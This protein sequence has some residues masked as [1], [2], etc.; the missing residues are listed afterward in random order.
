MKRILLIFMVCAL[1]ATPA[2]SNLTFTTS[3][4]LNFDVISDYTND[5]GDAWY[6]G[7]YTTTAGYGP[8]LPPGHVGLVAHAVGKYA[9]GDE[10]QIE[11]LGLGLTN[12]DLSTDDTLV[13][14]ISND[15]DDLWKYKLFVDDG[16]FAGTRYESGSWTSVSGY[17]GTAT[18]SLAYSELDTTS[19]IGI[20][21]GSDVKENTIHT[22][23]LIPAPGAILLGSI[24][25][26]L[27][28]WL[29]RR[30]TL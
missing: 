30:R 16:S 29:R 25:V 1:M 6:E 17:G 19:R 23:I 18:L 24:G 7:A 5:D 9:N 20:M 14:T 28:G 21:I 26:G 15:N 22:S 11:W 8:T 12:F 4:V 13:V 27:V 3:D 10:T 2:L